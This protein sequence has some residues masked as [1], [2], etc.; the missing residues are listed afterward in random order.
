MDF[1]NTAF[2]ADKSPTVNE[3]QEIL[4]YFFLGTIFVMMNIMIWVAMQFKQEPRDLQIIIETK[5]AQTSPILS[6][7][8][9]NSNS[10]DK[11]TKSIKKSCHDLSTQGTDSM[12]NTQESEIQ[13]I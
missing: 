11:F 13:K 9:S 2:E 3:K 12:T 5:M 6:R 4:Q 7:D 8:S 10:E 1:V